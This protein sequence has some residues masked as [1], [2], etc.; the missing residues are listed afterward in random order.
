MG[1][2]LYNEE[3]N[4]I[5]ARCNAQLKLLEETSE[6]ELKRI[7][8]EIAEC[9]KQ[10]NQIQKELDEIHIFLVQWLRE[11]NERKVKRDMILKEIRDRRTN[12]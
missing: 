1:N 2:R 7:D 5:Y 6:A 12:V 4:T 3:I 8:G 11:W 10:L 9:N